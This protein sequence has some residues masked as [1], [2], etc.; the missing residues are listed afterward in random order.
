ML[1]LL[2]LLLVL[3]VVSA[4]SKKKPHGHKGVLEVYNGKQ[5]PFKVTGDQNKKLDKGEA[6]CLSILHSTTE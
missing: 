1:S 5:I 6:V 2:C 3:A 4:S